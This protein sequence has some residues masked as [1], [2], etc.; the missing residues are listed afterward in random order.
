MRLT[1][2]GEFVRDLALGTLA[3]VPLVA[4]V[5]LAGAIETW[6]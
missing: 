4:L 6:R 2:L 5:A 3:L 1:P